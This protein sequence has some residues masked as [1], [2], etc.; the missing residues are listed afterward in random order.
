LRSLDTRT[1]RPPPKLAWRAHAAGVLQLCVFTSTPQL[2]TAAADCAIRL[3]AIKKCAVGLKRYMPTA[4]MGEINMCDWEDERV[5]RTEAWA[6]PVESTLRHVQIYRSDYC[7]N[8]VRQALDK[9]GYLTAPR[10]IGPP[11][12]LFSSGH[13]V[14]RRPLE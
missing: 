12:R 9:V 8:V 7:I 4:L 3:W 1:P 10:I 14:N 2:L 6:L 11:P 5:V 13:A